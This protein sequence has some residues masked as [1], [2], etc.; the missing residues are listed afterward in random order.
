MARLPRLPS[1]ACAVTQAPDDPRRTRPRLLPPRAPEGRRIS[2]C[3]A[4]RSPCSRGVRERAEDDLGASVSASSS[5]IS[6][7]PSRGRHASPE[8]FDIYDQCFHNLDIVW[9]WNA[10]AAHRCAAHRALGRSQ[11]P[12]QDRPAD[13]RR[14]ARPRRRTGAPSLRA[15]G[16]EPGR[17]TRRRIAC[18]RGAQLGC[19]RL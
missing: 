4:P 9:F 1:A 8:A 12:Y 3:W 15:A 14:L 5:S 11:R 18:C 10:A 2:A 6:S 7:A 17:T 13:A 16:P 19:L